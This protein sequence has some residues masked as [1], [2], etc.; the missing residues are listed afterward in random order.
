MN[1]MKVLKTSLCAIV[2]AVSMMGTPAH[3]SLDGQLNSV[4]NSMINLT[5]P[6]AYM[7]RTRGG[8]SGGSIQLR[9]EIVNANLVTFSPPSWQMGCGGIDFFG[10]SFSF[11][12]AEQFVH[13]MRA[14]AA[15]SV[16]YVFQLALEGVCP[17]CMANINKLQ[18]AIQRLNQYMGN[19]CQMAKGLVTSTRDL[20]KSGQFNDNGLFATMKG[21][22]NDVFNAF[23]DWDTQ[24]KTVEATKDTPSELP[25]N[26]NVVYQSLVESGAADWFIQRDNA[27]KTQ[28]LIMS[29]T[30]TVSVTIDQKTGKTEQNTLTYPPLL[31]LKDIVEGAKNKTI[32]RCKEVSDA[33]QCLELVKDQQ[34]TFKGLEERIVEIMNGNGLTDGLVPKLVRFDPS[35]ETTPAEKALLANMPFNMGTFIRNLALTTQDPVLL[36]TF[37]S[38][39]A[40]V[41]AL[42]IA[43]DMAEQYLRVATESLSASKAKDSDT[44]REMI[45]NRKAEIRH[46]FDVEM[47]TITVPSDITSVYQNL[48]RMY[49]LTDLN[50]GK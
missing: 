37:V 28:E 10:G 25:T 21:I 8:I 14:V 30:G 15:N 35:Y 7:T 41:W 9:N 40:K 27:R 1:T 34:I 42:Y 16:G 4:F 17:Q 2:L 11:I 48:I 45:A 6:D 49:R 38:N 3:A 43:R 19:S 26:G 31:T 46:E 44:V 13:L 36:R 32:Y 33:N 47:S 12:N 20:A 18:N 24:N 39:Y 5:T 29:F 22:G 23:T 50:G